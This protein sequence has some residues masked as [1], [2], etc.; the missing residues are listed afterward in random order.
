MTQET[1]LKEVGLLTRKPRKEA[2]QEEEAIR[3]ILETKKEAIPE[4]ETEIEREAHLVITKSEEEVN[5]EN[6]SEE[7]VILETKI[8]EEKYLAVSRMT[9][10]KNYHNYSPLLF[11]CMY[12]FAF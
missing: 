10:S 5:R 9:E 8:E 1:E 2:S 11:D 7:E 4:I 6:E 3:E 12:L